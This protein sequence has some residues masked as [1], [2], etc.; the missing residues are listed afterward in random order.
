MTE[1][2]SGP[3][4]GRLNPPTGANAPFI[5]GENPPAGGNA[6][7]GRSACL[8]T[9]EL[10]A[11]RLGELAEGRRAEVLAHVDGC[12][13]CQGRL[14]ELEQEARRFAS[15]VNVAAASVQIL[16]RLE[17]EVTRPRRAWLRW[18]GL[19]LP[20]AA[21]LAF[22]TLSAPGPDPRGPL[23]K[24]GG[25]SLQMM[26][27]GPAGV[28]PVAPEQALHAG[29]QIQF[30][31]HAAGHPFVIVVEVDGAGVVTALQPGERPE[32]WPVQ[33]SGTHVLPGSIILDEAVG[34]ERVFA[35]FSNAP[36]PVET[37]LEAVKAAVKAAGGDPRKVEALGLDGTVLA[38]LDFLKV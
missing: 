29:D 10:E 25:P 28:V 21:V 7:R 5:G 15:E 6:A 36:L 34:P 4:G 17:A 18:V 20:V 19:A 1:G 30:L 27:K 2:G 33:S 14:G 13:D 31:Y 24:G 3:V 23:L 35:V 16:A 12:A 9:I 22:V 11:H 37:V 38:V 8:R 26:L 32:S